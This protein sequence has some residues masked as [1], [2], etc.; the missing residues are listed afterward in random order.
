VLGSGAAVDL[1][2]AVF[3]SGAWRQ[4]DELLRL[5]VQQ[6][7][8]K[9]TVALGRQRSGKYPAVGEPDPASQLDATAASSRRGAHCLPPPGSGV[10][11]LIIAVVAVGAAP[12]MP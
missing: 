4:L 7:E 5:V 10:A 9:R 8:V 12:R 6:P 11:F 2:P 1:E 3:V